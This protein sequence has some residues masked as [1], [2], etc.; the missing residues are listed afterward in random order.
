MIE[1]DCSTHYL[2][3]INDV[4]YFDDTENECTPYI[5]Q[6]YLAMF[7]YGNYK[8][9]PNLWQRLKIIFNY[10]KTGEMYVD[11][12]ILNPDEAHKLIKFINDSLVDK[13][14]KIK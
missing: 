8:N 6:Y 13:D 2:Q 4:E 3:V 7:S 11:E 14:L 1:C 10:L 12:I 5:Q 9:K